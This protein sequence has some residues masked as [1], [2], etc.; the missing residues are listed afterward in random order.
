[1]AQLIVLLILI[2]GGSILYRRFVADAEKLARRRAEAEAE[3]RSGADGTL[4]EDPETG[5]YRLR[6]PDDRP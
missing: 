6:R 5:E 2:V 4:V 1:M 3:A